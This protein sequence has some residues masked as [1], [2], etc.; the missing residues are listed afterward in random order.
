MTGKRKTGL[1]LISL[2]YLSFVSLGLPDGLLGIAWPSIR[3]SFDLSIDALGALLV[4]FTAGYLI[5]SFSSG[6]LLARMSVGAL[7]ALSCL[8][9]AASLVGYALAPSW[10][11]L[12]ALGSLAGLGAG[13]IDA[14]LNTF[15]ATNFSARMVN[16]LH[17]C[18]GIGAAT[19]PVIMTTVLGANRP[20]QYGYAIVGIW[21]LLLAVCF[22]LTHRHWLGAS[23]AQE[24][25]TPTSIKATSSLETLRLTA[26][27]LSIAIFFVYTGIEAAAGAWAYKPVYRVATG[28]YG[29]GWRVG[30]RI[31]GRADRRKTAFGFHHNLRYSQS[32]IAILYYRHPDRR[33][34][35]LAQHRCH[36]QSYRSWVN[37]AYVGSGIPFVDCYD[38]DSAWRS[39]HSQRHRV[40]DRCCCTRPV[41]VARCDRVAC[42]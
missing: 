26:A 36:A 13:A 18:Y 12:V 20:W 14:G 8:A 9:T 1:L 25:E 40:P 41:S 17:A 27:W 22:S 33:G 35:D 3:A 38:A 4:M 29:D 34:A 7:L 11:M 10:W 2:A 15:A 42:R 23:K 24:S 21:Q 32:P 37:G 39:A 28:A 31:L 30:Q 19:G 16:W 6:R 5:S